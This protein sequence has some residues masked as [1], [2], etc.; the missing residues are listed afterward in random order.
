MDYKNP[1]LFQYFTG[2]R[3]GVRYFFSEF[4]GDVSL[5][6]AEDKALFVVCS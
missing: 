6:R 1:L 4:G 3:G 2:E 5:T